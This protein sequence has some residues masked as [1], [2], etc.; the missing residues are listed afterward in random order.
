MYNTIT[1]KRENK[2]I[3]TFIVIYFLFQG[4]F[5][6]IKEIVFCQICV[7]ISIFKEI[8]IEKKQSI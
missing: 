5:K 2:K 1:L 7:N 3:I 6:V 8:Q 4:L